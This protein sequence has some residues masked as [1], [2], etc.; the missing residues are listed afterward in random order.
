VGALVVAGDGNID[1]LGGRVDVAE[2]DHGDVGVAS[3]GDGLMVSPGVGHHQ[4]AGLAERGLDLISEGAGGEATGDGAAAGI[5]GELEDGP[6]GVGA[7][8]AH[9]HVLGILNGGD[10]ASSEQDLLPGLL[11]VDDVDSIILLLED[12]L[13]HGSLGVGRPEV[14]GGSQHLSDVIFSASES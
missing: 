7:A 10:G 14:G 9:E 2:G 1:E 12:V 4:E 13:L 3:L 11:Q 5:P 6:L 8:G